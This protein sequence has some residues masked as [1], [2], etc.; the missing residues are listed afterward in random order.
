MSSIVFYSAPSSSAS[1]VESALA[2]LA[3]PHDKVVFDLAAK[4]QRK[5]AF[6]KLNPNGKVPTLVVDGTPMF[7]A[8]AIMQWLGDRFGV[9]REAW[10]A[11]DSPV[12][13]RALSW[14]TWSYVTYGSA[15]SRL[16]QATHAQLPAELHSPAQAKHVQAELQQLLGLLDAELSAQPYLLGAQFSLADLIVGCVVRYSG[17]CGVTTE[18]HQ[19]VTAWMGRVFER[20]SLKAN[21]G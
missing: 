17:Y 5:P 4:D 20:P 18:A 7:E 12:R 2:E 15:L 3:V 14:S 13:L 11:F 16:V 6:L 19:H 10:P 8:L 21:W 1:P 9:A